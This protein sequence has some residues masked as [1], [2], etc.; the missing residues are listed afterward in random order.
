M[1]QIIKVFHDDSPDEVVVNFQDKV[2]AFHA[3]DLI[4]ASRKPG[5]SYTHF[6]V[7]LGG[8]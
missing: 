6:L 8:I 7:E 1:Y 4:E 3:L 2:S 5:T